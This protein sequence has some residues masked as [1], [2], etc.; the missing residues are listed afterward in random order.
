VL[1]THPQ[2][3]EALATPVKRVVLIEHQSHRLVI[4]FAKIAGG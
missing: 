4:R 3:I 1:T 2:I